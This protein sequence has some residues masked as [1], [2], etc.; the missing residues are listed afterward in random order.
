MFGLKQNL[1]LPGKFIFAFER[2]STAFEEILFPVGTVVAGLC[3]QAIC[4]DSDI[5]SFNSSSGTANTICYI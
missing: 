4:D 3:S 2:V 5:I 1:A